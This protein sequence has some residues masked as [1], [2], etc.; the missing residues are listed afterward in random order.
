MPSSYV[1]WTTAPGQLR[2]LGWIDRTYV[3]EIVGGDNLSQRLAAARTTPKD[4]E[5]LIVVIADR[6][7]DDEL[8]HTTLIVDRDDQ[9]CGRVFI[10][11]RRKEY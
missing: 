4:P 10:V 7:V 1:F 8:V 9:D 11:R 3:Y 2:G 5:D 6:Q